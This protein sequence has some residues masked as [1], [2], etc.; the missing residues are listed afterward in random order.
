MRPNT[1]LSQRLRN[2]REHQRLWRNHCVDKNLK[3]DWIE[4]LNSLRAFNLISICEGHLNG[5]S[6]PHGGLPHINLRLKPDLVTILANDWQTHKEKIQEGINNI[7]SYPLTSASIEL[8]HRYFKGIGQPNYR[9]DV[10]IRLEAF[11]ERS[12]N[13]QEITR[14]EWFEGSIEGLA[15]FDRFIENLLGFKYLDLLNI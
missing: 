12:S 9:E 7:T 8:R 15:E 3:D 13:N 5:R 2:C 11:R 14:D 10:V 4:S 6:N 1:I